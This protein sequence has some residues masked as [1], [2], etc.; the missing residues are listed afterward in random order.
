MEIK[1][2]L[3]QLDPYRTQLEKAENGKTTA[4]KGGSQ[5][6]RTAPQ[7]DR[8]SLSVEGRL[9]TE[10]YVAAQAAPDVRQ[11][12]VDALRERV[13]NGSYTID[14]RKVAEKLVTDELDLFR[15]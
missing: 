9:R 7:G 2:Y 15:S 5:P 3:K 12:K 6:E 14:A 11:E 8:I 10:A 4:R 1:T 13:N